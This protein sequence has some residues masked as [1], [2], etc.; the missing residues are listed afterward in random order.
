MKAVSS[1]R[2]PNERP[3]V[4]LTTVVHCFQI[5]IKL[6]TL[7][8]ER[9]EG[10]EKGKN[11][12]AWE[13]GG[14]KKGGKGKRKKGGRRKKEKGK[15]GGGSTFYSRSDPMFRPEIKCSVPACQLLLPDSEPGRKSV[16]PFL[17]HRCCICFAN[18]GDARLFPCSLNS[19]V[20]RGV[21]FYC[22]LRAIAI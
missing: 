12:E 9:G 5:R 14:R 13:E 16:L 3:L 4:H 1:N 11:K 18:G 20:N 21:G 19:K 7:Q 15:G 17:L 8:K 22:F 6:K 2:G 10:R